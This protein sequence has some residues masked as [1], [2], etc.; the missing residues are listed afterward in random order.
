MEG[1]AY[2]QRA[3]KSEKKKVVIAAEE[4]KYACIRSIDSN[5]I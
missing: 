5:T 4:V 1:R 2:R 3:K